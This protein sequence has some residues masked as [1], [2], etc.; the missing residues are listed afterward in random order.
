MVRYDRSSLEFWT[1]FFDV[2]RNLTHPIKKV[3]YSG[4]KTKHSDRATAL[5]IPYVLEVTN[6]AHLCSSAQ[7][8]ACLNSDKLPHRRCADWHEV[9]RQCNFSCTVSHII[10]ERNTILFALKW[11]SMWNAY[12]ISPHEKQVLNHVI[13]NLFA[14]SIQKCVMTNGTG[15]DS[16]S[17]IRLIKFLCTVAF[18]M[19]S[20]IFHASIKLPCPFAC[21]PSGFLELSRVSLSD[22]DLPLPLSSL[23]ERW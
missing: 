15:N 13:C 11:G 21:S 5:P 1:T 9:T 2:N 12:I 14:M 10:S 3:A 18:L 7:F 19:N 6:R 16:R 4:C 22:L 17:K 20:K 8:L 23:A